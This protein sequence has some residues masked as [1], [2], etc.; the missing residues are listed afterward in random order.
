MILREVAVIGE[1]E[2]SVA[3]LEA[4]RE[5]GLDEGR[6][7]SDPPE[8]QQI[9]AQLRQVWVRIGQQVQSLIGEKSKTSNPEVVPRN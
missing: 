8:V 6:A 9:E 7:R 2:K 1:L 4:G 3:S 5:A